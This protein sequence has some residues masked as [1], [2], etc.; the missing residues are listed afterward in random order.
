MVTLLGISS[1]LQLSESLR[2]QIAKNRQLFALNIP[3]AADLA[4]AEQHRAAML[5]A[6]MAAEADPNTPPPTGTRDKL[7]WP[8]SSQ[9]PWNMPIGSG[10]VMVPAGFA[11][12]SAIGR[13]IVPIYMT[14][15]AGLRNLIV[16]GEKQYNVQVPVPTGLQF[17][18]VTNDHQGNFCIVILM[19]DGDRIV[20]GQPVSLPPFGD[21][22]MTY[23]ANNGPLSGGDETIHGAGIT[24]AHGG[25]GT[26]ALGG[27]IRNGEM[28][29]PGPLR[30]ALGIQ[31]E[32]A[33]YVF[34]SSALTGHRWPA[35][36]HDSYAASGYHGTNP[37]VRMGALLALPAT[38]DVAALGSAY[39]RKI[40]QCLIDYGAYLTDD[41]WNPNQFTFNVQFGEIMGFTSI[42]PASTG[43]LFAD[44]QRIVP[45]LMVVDNNSATAI[46]G[47]GTPRVALAPPLA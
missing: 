30:H 8:F 38:F 44:M 32:A 28:D 3:A 13:D 42:Y 34:Y 33:R 22:H 25:S 45:A 18:A 2:V 17:D 27:V 29:A 10:A 1:M 4:T 20:Q 40:A 21:I 36:R 47:G 15:T 39:G 14:Y 5:A 41:G 24:G 12:P 43:P 37:A 46:G 16:D 6:I 23:K 35:D 31:V 11:P 19:P 9:S 26:S 7:L